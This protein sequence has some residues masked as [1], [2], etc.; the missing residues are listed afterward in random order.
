MPANRARGKPLPE[1]YIEAL[2]VACKI[3]ITG[4]RYTNSTQVA[5]EIGISTQSLRK[6]LKYGVNK[7]CS[8]DVHNKIQVWE[9]GNR[10]IG[11]VEIGGQPTRTPRFQ[12]TKALRAALAKE[13]QDKF[14]PHPMLKP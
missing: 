11:G 7:N 13:A 5:K 6:I 1:Y 9:K 2:H 10:N 4:S 3:S 12:S 8:A 14:S